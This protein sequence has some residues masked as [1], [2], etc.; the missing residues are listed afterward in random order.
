MKIYITCENIIFNNNNLTLEYL[1]LKS[2]L[3][4]ISLIVK[5]CMLIYTCAFKSKH[6][7]S[8][9]TISFWY[10]PRKNYKICTCAQ[11]FHKKLTHVFRHAI[12]I[13]PYKNSCH[14]PHPNKKNSLPKS[15][16][17]S[18]PFK[19]VP[20]IA[21]KLTIKI[22]KNTRLG[23]QKTRSHVVS[24]DCTSSRSLSSSGRSF[25]RDE[26]LAAVAEAAAAAVYHHRRRRRRSKNTPSASPSRCLLS[27]PP[28][29][30]GRRAVV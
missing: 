5:A 6:H 20:H 1:T 22:K 18:D 9:K 13:I 8:I 3:I 21:Q 2:Y 28:P 26:P 29:P 30:R 27:L 14:Y 11:R 15:I 10:N 19:H 24:L 17:T 7:F 12:I 25:G 4:K 23:V 16:E